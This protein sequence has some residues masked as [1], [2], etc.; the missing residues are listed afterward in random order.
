MRLPMLVISARRRA[1][2]G[3]G[4]DRNRDRAGAHRFQRHLAL[5]AIGDDKV[6]L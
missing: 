1:R 4:S 5:E 3:R 2:H 6:P